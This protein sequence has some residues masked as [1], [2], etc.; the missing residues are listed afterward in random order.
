MRPERGSDRRLVYAV[1]ESLDPGVQVFVDFVAS[2]VDG[3]NSA[4]RGRPRRGPKCRATIRQGWG[5][6]LEACPARADRSA[7]QPP[8]VQ[9][10]SARFIYSCPVSA[11]SAPGCRASRF[12]KAPIPAIPPPYHHGRLGITALPSVLQRWSC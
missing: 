7:F 6:V 4:A 10:P 12:A 9:Q 8:S 3:R 2:R 11:M 1:R 5:N